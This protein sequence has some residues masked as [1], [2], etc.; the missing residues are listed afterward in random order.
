MRVPSSAVFLPPKYTSIATILEKITYIGV[1]ELFLGKDVDLGVFAA[2]LGLSSA[3]CGAIIECQIRLLE[4]S[5][6]KP[7]VRPVIM[8]LLQ[9]AADVYTASHPLRQAR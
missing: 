5:F 6:W 3:I 8:H 1:L 7:E 2:S 9:N 4:K